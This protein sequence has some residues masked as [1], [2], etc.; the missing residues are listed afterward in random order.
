MWQVLR[1]SSKQQE[2]QG[3]NFSGCKTGVTVTAQRR[4]YLQSTLHTPWLSE[5]Q[6]LLSFSCLSHGQKFFKVYSC[7]GFSFYA[8]LLP[9]R[10]PM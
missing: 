1:G 9:H 3:V 6:G 7:V 8:M 2:F 5:A 4:R 10:Q